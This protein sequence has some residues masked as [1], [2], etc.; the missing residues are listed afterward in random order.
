MGLVA[1]YAP[2]FVPVPVIL[3]NFSSNLCAE[4]RMDEESTN[5]KCAATNTCAP[6]LECLS[7]RTLQAI[8]ILGFYITFSLNIHQ[9]LLKLKRTYS[10]DYVPRLTH[11]CSEVWYD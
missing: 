11:V 9:T 1:R 6:A 7:L 3:S 4:L 2:N 5:G 8:P 10:T